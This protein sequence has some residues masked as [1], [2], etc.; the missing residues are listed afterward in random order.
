[1]A[2]P[3]TPASTSAAPAT[4]GTIVFVQGEA[5]LRDRQGK[6]QAIKPGDAVAEGQEIVTTA[7]AVVDVQLP[8]GAKLSIGPDRQ[9][10]L[11]D[12][13]F[14]TSAPEP[15][16]NV[17]S[18]LGADAD[19]VIQA[20]NTGGDPFAGLEDPAAGLNGGGNS[21]QTHDFVRLVR[22]LEDVTPLAFNYTSSSD[23][24]DFLPV[25]SIPAQPTVTATN[26]PPVATD[27]PAFTT[28]EDEATTVT[29]LT[30]DSDP[31][32]DPISVTRATAPNG[33]VTLNPDGTLRYVPNPDFNGTDT[34]T[35]TISDGKGGTATATVTVNVTPVN[36][37]PVARPDTASTN[38]DTPVILPVLGNDSDADGDPLTVTNA[39]VNPAQGSVVIN[40]DGTLS[41]TPAPNFN[42][43]AQITYTIDD[44]K[45]GTTTAVVTVNVALVNDAP[46]ARDDV[47]GLVKTDTLPATGN[48]ITN[49]AGLD[50]DLDGDTL[51]VSAVG[52]TPVAGATVVNGLF[53]TLTIQPNGEYGYVQDVTNP[54]IV[55]LAPTGTLQD[56]FTYTVSDGKGGTATATLTLNIAGANTPPVAQ[57][58]TV[59]TNE[60]TPL[61]FPVLGND[62]DPEGDPLTVTGATVDPAQGSVV[63]NPDGTLSFTPAPNFNGPAQITYTIDD[64]K[65]GTT[66]AVVTV[67]VAP[68]N[69]A[70]VANDTAARGAEDATSIP[71]T[72][73]GT[74]PDGS[75]ASFTL[76]TLPTNG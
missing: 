16:E 64:G 26:Q 53:G 68:V 60:D 42:G 4:Q 51:T 69:D 20:L 14:A 70:P 54:A 25:S 1:M 56:R 10:L 71:V 9:V 7:G 62:S 34:I 12:E 32:G 75:V 8:S 38:E 47:D 13:L 24:I 61:T 36:D 55:G 35:Y 5:Y 73:N 40:P 49:P 18:S 46:V 3:T 45:G 43:P 67:N 23:G 15:T 63:I 29:V 6:L 19:K 57:P 27:D 72:L 58:D 17:V 48:L 37:P 28:R 39:T 2:T 31:D 52:A 30:N 21:D 74:D 22:I 33:T 44:G 59:S 50:T 76:G 41:F 65:G 66:T 11:N